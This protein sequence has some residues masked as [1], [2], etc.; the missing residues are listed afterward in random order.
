MRRWGTRGRRLC[1]ATVGFAALL[2]TSEAR[3]DPPRIE[4]PGNAFAPPG[5][6]QGETVIAYALGRADN[7]GWRG[8]LETGLIL[9]AH[10]TSSR[11]TPS[12]RLW[13]I[14]GRFGGLPVAGD[15][16]HVLVDD[17][18]HG[19][20]RVVT[21]RGALGAL[22]HA[23]LDDPQQAAMVV[24][25]SGLPGSAG[26]SQA[27]P[28]VWPGDQSS[29]LGWL[30][31]P[32]PDL[33]ALSNPTFFV[34]AGLDSVNTVRDRARSG[35]GRIFA[36]DPQTTPETA[37]VTL[38]NL[39]GDA[40]FLDGL[41]FEATNCVEPIGD[42]MLC[43]PGQVAA[44]DALG[45][46]VYDA[47]NWIFDEGQMGEAFSEVNAYA[48]AD[49]MAA[50][51]EQH[52]LSKLACGRDAP[53]ATITTNFVRYDDVG[54]IPD[55]GGIYTGA[56]ES[57][58][59]LHQGER[60]AAWDATVVRHEVAHAAIESLSPDG[61]ATGEGRSIG[62][63]REAEA[64]N[65][66]VADFLA[67]ASLG[68]PSV[69]SYAFPAS[70]R[71]LELDLSFPR[72]LV[73]EPHADGMIVSAALWEAYME[74]G[75]PFVVAVLDTMSMLAADASWTEMATVL[76]VVVARQLGEFAVPVVTDAFAA[77]GIGAPRVVAWDDL[78]S[79]TTKA[80]HAP[81]SIVVEATADAREL[82]TPYRP[83]SFQ[84]RV[85]PP[86]GAHDVDFSF[87]VEGVDPSELSVFIRYG[88][89]VEFSFMEKGPGISTVEATHTEL[90]SLDATALHASGERGPIYLALA[91]AAAGWP[92]DGDAVVRLGSLEFSYDEQGETGDDGGGG[93]DGGNE[94]LADG[95]DSTTGE[96]GSDDLGELDGSLGCA[97]SSSRSGGG[98]GQSWLLLLLAGF[99]SRRARKN[100]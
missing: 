7:W 12:L 71:S 34:S 13:T 56:C 38:D 58:I 81:A 35:T 1:L 95:G 80:G 54:P 74:L 93:S 22:D 83:A 36:I 66:G 92:G 17:E 82:V 42:E 87:V 85:D 11:A 98:S 30:I 45:D 27:A 15:L 49:A 53:A 52:G 41:V 77:R 26:A 67:A 70:A 97:C 79:A 23:E 8:A 99:V 3:A 89:P 86:E 28:I 46:F 72:D 32:P 63:V 6:D 48:H 57:L 88:A 4:T 39:H 65:E 100:R 10:V 90:L 59:V 31:D 68:W 55:D 20:I 94:G 60:D 91:N 69:G 25:G 19:R 40:P 64:L 44:A 37:L 96:D 18:D 50:W 2:A 29:Q 5:D 14:S 21:H 43:T 84:I 24:A 47:P 78:A 33:L 62:F 61:L 76:R 73:G 51:L 16:A 9:E 75:E